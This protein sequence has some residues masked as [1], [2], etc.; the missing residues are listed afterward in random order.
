MELIF[1]ILVSL[2]IGFAGGRVKNSA[3][4]KAVSD[5]ISSL[6]AK[7]KSAV[8]LAAADVLSFVASVKSKL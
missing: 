7:A 8:Q 2:G 5:E 4:L 6:E 3:K 1:I